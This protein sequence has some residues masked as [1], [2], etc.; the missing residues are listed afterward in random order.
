MWRLLA[1]AAAILAGAAALLN[2]QLEAGPPRVEAASTIDAHVHVLVPGEGGWTP[3]YLSMLVLLEPGADPTQARAVAVNGMVDR[4]PAGTIVAAE[5]A[6]GL[7]EAAYLPAGWKW[8]DGVAAWSYNDAGQPDDGAFVDA[9]ARAAETWT[10]AG[11]RFSFSHGPPTTLEP[12]LCESGTRDGA[13]AIG[14]AES[15][16]G[17]TLAVTCTFPKSGPNAFESD[18]Q[19]DSSRNW[20]F[21]ESNAVIDFE[22]VALHELGH[23]VGLGHSGIAASVM[24]GTYKVGSIRRDLHTDDLAGLYSLYGEADT[25]TPSPTSSPTPTPSPTPTASPSPAPT[26]PGDPQVPLEDSPVFVPGLVSN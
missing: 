12:S 11:A 20:T 6:A 8:A 1:P 19:F 14:W 4:L 15:L 5:P 18:V 22:S 3:V 7:I 24:T 13:N 9:I 2:V 16:P 26:L 25:P 10:A 23:V 21:A 17:T